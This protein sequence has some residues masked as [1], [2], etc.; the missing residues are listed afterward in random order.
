MKGNIISIT[1]PM[2]SG[3]TTELLRIYTR[4]ILAKQKSLIIK[5]IIDKRY[6]DKEVVSHDNIKRDAI[7]C[8][9]I[10]DSLKEINKINP[11]NIFIDEAQF[12]DSNIL[13]FVETI[14][15]R[16]I[17][18]YLCFLNQTSEG[19]PF[20]FRDKKQDVG[21]LLAISDKIISLDAVC[22]KC[23]KPATKSF[24]LKSSGNEV[25]VGGVERYEP[26]CKDDWEPV[27]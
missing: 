2:F 26:R 12:F 20:L 8:K 22:S 27:K 5:P 23:G 10:N 19:K 9:N 14:S 13:D 17:N 16:N 11:N 21:Y 7:V 4:T 3:K 25:D 15:N 24:K 6:S 1:G 18:I